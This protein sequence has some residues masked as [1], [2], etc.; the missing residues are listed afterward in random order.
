[1]AIEVKEIQTQC[2]STILAT[3]YHATCC[4]HMLSLWQKLLQRALTIHLPG[5]CVCKQVCLGQ[6]CK[7]KLAQGCSKQLVCG[8]WCGG[9][10]GE[11]D[12]LPCLHVS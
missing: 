7:E 11:A 10:A 9:V 6:G 5:V 4:H 1:M 2:L 3:D 12:C 8:H